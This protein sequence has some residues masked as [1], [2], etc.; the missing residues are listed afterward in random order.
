VV[1]ILL[2]YGL[3]ADPVKTKRVRLMMRERSAAIA[4]MPSLAA[5]PAV[6][7]L[8]RYLVKLTEHT[9][10]E[11]HSRFDEH[12]GWSNY[13][14]HQALRE[15][16]TLGEKYR[17]YSSSWSEQR[18]YADAALA[19][20]I[21]PADATPASRQLHASMTA[22][23][24][25]AEPR[26]TMPPAGFTTTKVPPQG[27]AVKL[28]SSG[29]VVTISCAPVAV[30]R[31]SCDGGANGEEDAATAVTGQ[32]LLQYR[33]QSLNDTDFSRFRSEYATTNERA[34]GK[35]NL[36]LDTCSD[37]TMGCAVSAEWGTT[38]VAAYVHGSSLLLHIGFETAAAVSST[39]A[40]ST[41]KNAN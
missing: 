1:L 36:S 11:S 10:G 39:V 22:A 8:T 18:G 12:V 27:G 15:D 16:S 21:A 24:V 6:R 41:D 3:S 35:N 31:V 30:T 4:A 14:L 7:N 28:P 19:A 38:L 9:F 26:A 34:Y 25:A 32:S 20:L 17:N 13:R 33:Y 37:H 29:C 23:M 2:Q 5:D 40:R